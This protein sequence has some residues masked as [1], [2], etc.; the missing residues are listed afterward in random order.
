MAAILMF[1][2][3]QWMWKRAGY[4]LPSPVWSV[5]DGGIFKRSIEL[6]IALPTPRLCPQGVYSLGLHGGQKFWVWFV[7]RLWLMYLLALNICHEPDEPPMNYDSDFTK[8]ISSKSPGR[9]ACGHHVCTFLDTHLPMFTFHASV[10]F[11]S[12]F[13][14]YFIFLERISVLPLWRKNLP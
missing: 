7:I 6:F 11:A 14:K 4:F 13:K 3:Q 10:A 9:I 12:C 5:G 2:I 8:F 1:V